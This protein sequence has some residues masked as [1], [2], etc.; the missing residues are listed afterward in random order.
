[1]ISETIKPAVKP[2]PLVTVQT[3]EQSRQRVQLPLDIN[4]YSECW[5]EIR[6]KTKPGDNNWAVVSVETL[7]AM[8]ADLPELRQQKQP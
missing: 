2:I 6:P 4:P 7:R 5:V 1:M 3:D 8:L